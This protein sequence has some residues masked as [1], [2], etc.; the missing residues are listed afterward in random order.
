MYGPLFSCFQGQRLA[1][2]EL[3]GWLTYIQYC[4]KKLIM[5]IML[6][7]LQMIFN[8]NTWHYNRLQ[9]LYAYIII[10]H[11]I[12]PAYFTYTPSYRVNMASVYSSLILTFMTSYLQ[13]HPFS[14]GKRNYYECRIAEA[15]LIQHYYINGGHWQFKLWKSMH[16]EAD[17][18]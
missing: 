16:N 8:V 13:C 14:L 4:H 9:C 5:I 11:K 15:I 18:Q 1:S 12:M 17:Y 3:R 6:S 2:K 10:I 7:I